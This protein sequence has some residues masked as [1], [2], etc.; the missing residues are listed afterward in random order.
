MQ[1]AGITLL[2]FI[3][4]VPL[5]VGCERAS[6]STT[7]ET[8]AGSSVKR[9]NDPEQ[10]ATGQQVY[11]ANCAGCHGEN[12]AGATNW[13]QPGAD[14]RY[15]APPLDGSGH[16]WHHSTAV[17]IQMIRNGSPDG[18][19]NMPAWGDKLSEQDVRAVIAWF[20]S[21]WPDPVYAA[22]YDMQQRSPSE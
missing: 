11:Q 2:C 3:G 12:A 16:A 4:A 9:I 19:G 15:P 21:L 22:W 17:L 7:V 14:G 8:M 5:L 20:Q 6:D 18:Q 10:I 13:R 1:I